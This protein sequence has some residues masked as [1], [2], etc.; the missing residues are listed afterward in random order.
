MALEVVKSAQRQAPAIA[1]AHVTPEPDPKGLQ[2]G[3]K[4]RRDQRG[5]T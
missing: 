4:G 2:L 3:R 1:Q 5:K